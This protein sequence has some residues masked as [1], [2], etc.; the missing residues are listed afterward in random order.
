MRTSIFPP[1]LALVLAGCATPGNEYP[2]LLPRPIEQGSF[3]EPERPRPEPQADAALEVRIAEHRA[4]FTAA[5]ARFDEA[6]ATAERLARAARGASAGSDAWLDAQVALA[7]LDTLRNDSAT[8][9]ADIERLEIDRAVEGKPPYPA[10]T[11]LRSDAE[12]RARL[13]QERIAHLGAM[14]APA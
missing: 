9:L 11:R 7:E 13:E 2:S 4:A 6:A 14:L 5:S 12:A 1:I 3:A 8:L 10:L